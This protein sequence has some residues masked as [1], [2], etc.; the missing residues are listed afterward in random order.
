MDFNR[1]NF[2]QFQLTKWSFFLQ[3]T[4]H[5]APYVHPRLDSIL[6]MCRTFPDCF[7]CVSFS[8][9]T[10]YKKI[11]SGIPQECEPI[12][13]IIRT[14]ILIGLIWVKQLAKVISRQ[15]KN[16]RQR[17]VHLLDFP[18]WMQ[19]LLSADNLYK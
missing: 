18:C 19:L 15:Q 7:L 3:S 2:P 17:V 5:N 6:E 16:G 14:N 8:K 4:T 10:F 13:I 1:A 11:L 9:F 12:C